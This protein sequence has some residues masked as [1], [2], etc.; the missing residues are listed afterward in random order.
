MNDTKRPGT[1]FLTVKL[2]N[3]IY[4]FSYPKEYH[5]QVKNLIKLLEW[6]K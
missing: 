2:G 3:L 5:P 4:G 6:E 1:A